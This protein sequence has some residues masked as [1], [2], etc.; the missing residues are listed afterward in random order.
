M[1]EDIMNETGLNET[2]RLLQGHRSIRRFKKTAIDS[3]DLDEIIKAG[4]A[5]ATSSFCQSV[6][7][8]RITNRQ[9]RSQCAEWSGNQPY[10]ESAPEFLVFCADLS[11]AADLI[12]Q[13]ETQA[14]KNEGECNER[15][16]WTEQFITAT[17]DVG[18]FAQNCATAAQSLGF[19]ICYIG[20]IRNKIQEVSD[21]LD[22]PQLVIPLFGMCIGHPDQ[23]PEQKPRLPTET[24]FFE[25]TYVKP[26]S[27]RQI[28]RQ[29]DQHVK[30]YYEQRTKCKLS[31]TWSEQLA[32]Q[33]A[34]QTRP[35][36]QAFLH[37]KGLATR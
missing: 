5:A 19:G 31:Q 28:S 22:L 23:A 20:G 15:F 7:V 2:I 10:V 18:L 29:Y 37:S 24:V 26:E 33:A 13:L 9:L 35:H 34:T 11:R 30:H 14:P 27:Y 25:N 32:T 6:T 3:C 12:A 16:A 1:T 17:L 4:Q 21:A 36:M 8:I